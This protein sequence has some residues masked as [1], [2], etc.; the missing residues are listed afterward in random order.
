METGAAPPD[1]RNANRRAEEPASRSLRRSTW[2][3]TAREGGTVSFLEDTILHG[4]PGGRG[5]P[6]SGVSHG[7]AGQPTGRRTA[8]RFSR[9]SRARLS[10]RQIEVL[11]AV[12]QGSRRAQG[13]RAWLLHVKGHQD[14]AELRTDR[15]GNWREIIGVLARYAD[16]T[17]RTTRPTWALVAGEAQVSRATVARCI[18]WL[19]E[20]GLLGVVETGS[21][22]L[23]RCGVLYGIDP[24]AK[25]RAAEYVL[26]VRAPARKRRS[27]PICD[28]GVR[29]ETETPSRTRQGPRSTPP[30][31]RAADTPAQ[32]RWPLTR[33]PAT[34][35]EGLIAAEELR[36]RLPLLA[37]LSPEYL[38]HLLGAYWLDAGWTP[39]DCLHCLD[40]RPD[41]RLQP[42]TDRVR[43]VPGWIRYRLGQW[44][45][46]SGALLLSPSQ[47]RAREHRR[48]RAEQDTRRHEREQALR[49]AADHTRR[50][51]EAR[52]ALAASRAQT[53][54]ALEDADRLLGATRPTRPHT[55]PAVADVRTAHGANQWAAVARRLLG[56]RDASLR[57]DIL[58]AARGVSR[59]PQP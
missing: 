42:Y 57:A 17:D 35:T 48:I 8:V 25:N 36:R 12:P 56:V 23:L 16:W 1:N 22:P 47:I 18:A 26:T 54:R 20:R 24:D 44:H 6:H 30:R 55:Q 15:Q 40:H 11:S 14:Y 51:E 4:P 45:G 10:P 29:E 31:A 28:G 53:A 38:R 32:D 37:E 13:Q 19:V 50:A 49:T 5:R 7:H 58:G 39:A 27:R 21:T 34:R 46:R 59:G 33:R 41:G 2:S 43:H 3:V 52:Q 9:A